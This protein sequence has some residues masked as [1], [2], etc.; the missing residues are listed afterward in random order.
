MVQG[1]RQEAGNI[2]SEQRTEGSFPR[3]RRVRSDT[4]H[5]SAA[6]KAEQE[7]YRRGSSAF[8]SYE[9]DK[10]VFFFTTLT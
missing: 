8:V 1:S 6:Q 2:T 10:G 3:L 4:A 9:R 7:W 5:M